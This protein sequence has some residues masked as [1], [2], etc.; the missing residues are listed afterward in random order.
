MWQPTEKQIQSSNLTRF[1]KQMGHDTYESLYDWSVTDPEFW[2]ELWS[3]LDIKGNPGPT[4]LTGDGTILGS[5]W[6][7]EGQLSYAENIFSAMP[8]DAVIFWSESKIQKKLSR[9]EIYDD[10]SRLIQWLAKAGVKPQDRIAAILTN[11]PEALTGLLATSSLGAIWSSC[12]PDFGVQG[13]VDRFAQIEPKILIAIPEY[14]YGSKTLSIADNIIGVI[15]KLPSVEHILVIDDRPATLP[16][17][18]V[19]H[20]KVKLWSECIKH[21]QASKIMFTPFPFNHPL[22]IL[23]SSGTTGVPKCIIHGA[24]NAL[25]QH[26]KEQQLHCD[27]RPNDRL[28]YF[29][30]LGWM[31]W[32]WLMSAP[33]SG[34]TLLLYDG[35]PFHS[36][37]HILFDMAQET[38]MTHFGTSARYIDALKKTK[39]RPE[40]SHNLTSLRMLMST[41]STLSPE[42]FDYIA[43][44]IKEDM[45]ICSISGGTDIVSCFVLGNPLKPVHRG[46]IQTAGLGMN[47]DIFDEHGKPVKSGKGELVCKTPFP[48]RPLGFWND[49]D[50]HKFKAAY[51]ERFPNVW[52]HGDYIEKTSHDGYII[53]GRSDAVLNPGGIRI[54]TSEIYRQVEQ[55]EEVLE[56]IVIGQNWHNDVRVVLF[57]KLRPGVTLSNH[58]ID[59]IKAQIKA[60]AS[61]RHVPAKILAVPDIPRTKSGKITE[62]AVRSVVH[63]EEVKNT[64][65]LDNPEALAYF[66]NLAELQN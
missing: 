58:L 4:T 46:E 17:K 23:Y 10:T 26:M 5:T 66:K 22:Y 59:R 3:F 20:P 41:G 39:L 43:Q 6:F 28:F 16:R 61:P 55:I 50:R 38:G 36:K 42:S 11:R 45:P 40:A 53:H 48:V 49:E 21:I 52:A 31:M 24:G 62:L 25:I 64:E 9:D 60:N 44:N 18:L 29:T 15:E 14:L 33:A 57:V 19:T 27:I 35:S 32:N 51:F 8:D 47:I 13:I 34:A 12:S 54:G 2:R 56:S 65:T 1:M 37:R 7:P 30:T 63:G